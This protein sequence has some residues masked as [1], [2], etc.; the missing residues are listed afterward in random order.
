[1]PEFSTRTRLI[2][3]SLRTDG[4]H[5]TAG[6]Y[7][8][9]HRRYQGPLVVQTHRLVENNQSENRSALQT[10]LRGGEEKPKGKL[11]SGNRQNVFRF[12]NSIFLFSK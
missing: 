3:F 6:Q 1:M 5:K 7:E 8:K 2:Y 12:L 9:R 10:E 11:E 4:S